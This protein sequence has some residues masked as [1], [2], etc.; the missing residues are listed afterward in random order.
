ML[1]QTCRPFDLFRKF[2][3][4]AMAV[5]LAICFTVLAPLFEFHS[6]DS[7]YWLILGALILMT[8]TVFFI[9]QWLLGHTDKL[10][11]KLRRRKR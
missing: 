2:I 9:M 11:E 10:A 7:Q 3:W 4:G 5:A 8:P 6:G 1:F